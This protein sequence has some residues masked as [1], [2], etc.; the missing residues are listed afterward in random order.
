MIIT[1]KNIWALFLIACFFLY[2]AQLFAQEDNRSFF[3]NFFSSTPGD[4]IE[5]EPPFGIDR[6]SITEKPVI[7]AEDF[8]KPEQGDPEA[9]NQNTVEVPFKEPII[10]AEDFVKPEQGDPGVSNQDTVVTP[11]KEPMIEKQ[12]LVES[13]STDSSVLEKD[14]VIIPPRGKK[15]FS[16]AADFRDP[17]M[18]LRGERVS[19][20]KVLKPGVTVDGI[21]F[22]S[23]N[24]SDTFVE[25]VYRDSRF[26]IKDVFGKVDHLEGG[27]CLYCHRGIERISKNH[28]FRCTKCHEGNRRRRTLPAAH[29]NLIANP[30]DLDHASKY[31]GKCHADQIEQVEQSNM[32]T[33]KSMIEVTRYAWGAQGEGE[34]L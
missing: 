18:L 14:M 26:R 22:N 7:E 33:G 10:E 6:D 3:E 11:S 19:A 20:E 9:L 28:K 1:K 13:L 34:K 27:G 23:Y 2:A 31:C 5:N 30:S 21:Q 15:Q 29:T 17:F 24:D 32:A 25:R 16:D 8:A 4:S 12:N